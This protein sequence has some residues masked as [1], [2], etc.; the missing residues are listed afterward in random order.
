MTDYGNWTLVHQ[1]R[2]QAKALGERVFMTFGS[3]EPDLTYA[4][5]DRRSDAA[6]AALAGRSI[7]VVN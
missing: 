6:A 4:G 1:V 3:G 5:L 7:W 2:E